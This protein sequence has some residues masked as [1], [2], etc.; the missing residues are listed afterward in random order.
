VPRA[1]ASSARFFVSAAH[2][3]LVSR[4]VLLLVTFSFSFSFFFEAEARPAN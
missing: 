2:F 3:G 1:G 4:N